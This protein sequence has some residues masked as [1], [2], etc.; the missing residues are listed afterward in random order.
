MNYYPASLL[1]LSTY[2]KMNY[3][4]L[5]YFLMSWN[6]L[7]VGYTF[8]RDNQAS[9]AERRTQKAKAEGLCKTTNRH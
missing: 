2:Q 6:Q 3:Q 9:Q 4:E 8:G 7:V 1:D 5:I